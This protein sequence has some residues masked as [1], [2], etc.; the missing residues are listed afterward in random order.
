MQAVTIVPP[1][2]VHMES[3]D[4]PPLLPLL[5]ALKTNTIAVQLY[6]VARQAA[7]VQIVEA[8]SY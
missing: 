7:D 4:A 2:Q 1:R 6:L 5:L 8:M 3:F